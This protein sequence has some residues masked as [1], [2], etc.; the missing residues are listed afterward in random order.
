MVQIKVFKITFSTKN[1]VDAYLYLQNKWN[2][3]LHRLQFVKYFNILKWESRFTLWPG[4]T[5]TAADLPVDSY[6]SFVLTLQ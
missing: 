6:R 1:L 3:G 5:V 4:Y 2:L